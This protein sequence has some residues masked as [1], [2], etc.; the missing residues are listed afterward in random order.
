MQKLPLLVFRA[1]FE[2]DLPT[3]TLVPFISLFE[4]LNYLLLPHNHLFSLYF[5]ENFEEDIPTSTTYMSWPLWMCSLF[6]ICASKTSNHLPLHSCTCLY[7]YL[8][9]SVP[10]SLSLYHCLCLFSISFCVC[11]CVAV[12][13]SPSLPYLLSICIHSSLNLFLLWLPTR[14]FLSTF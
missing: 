2:E 3:S 11:R 5:R 12:S 9:L 6:G 10:V 14:Y 8:C 13:L 1:N 7:V 4:T